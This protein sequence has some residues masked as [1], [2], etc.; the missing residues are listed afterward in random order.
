MFFCFSLTFNSAAVHEI[1]L[2]KSDFLLSKVFLSSPGSVCAGCGALPIQWCEHDG[3]QDPQHWEQSSG[4]HHWE[5]V[6]GAAAGSA[7]TWLGSTGRLHDREWKNKCLHH[8]PQTSISAWI[9]RATENTACVSGLQLFPSE[10]GPVC[11]W[12][13]NHSLQR[14]QSDGCRNKLS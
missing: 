2:S 4:L 14:L 13:H 8:P 11:A 10:C 5:M 3:F 9:A 12:D 7:Q 1:S 6:N